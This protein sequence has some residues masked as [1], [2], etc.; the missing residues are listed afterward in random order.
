M[1]DG[2][3]IKETLKYWVQTVEKFKLST[4]KSIGE[5]I[6][7]WWLEGVGESKKKR[8]SHLQSG[9]SSSGL[10]DM[11]EEEAFILLS[12]SEH[13]P[14]YDGVVEFGEHGEPSNDHHHDGG[15]DDGSIYGSDK[16]Q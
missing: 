16:D 15:G 13:K 7:L 12:E 2:R 9:M 11:E 4:W 3:V 8:R 6:K 1:E 10:S 5:C 14:E